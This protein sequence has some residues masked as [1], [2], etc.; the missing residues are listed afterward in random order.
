M[1]SNYKDDT[2]TLVK[3]KFLWYECADYYSF[4]LFSFWGKKELQF[5]D[6][7]KYKEIILSD[8]IKKSFV[9]ISTKALLE[10]EIGIYIPIDQIRFWI[11]R[12]FKEHDSIV[13]NSKINDFI[14]FEFDGWVVKLSNYDCVG[15]KVIF[16]EK[17]LENFNIRVK[18]IV[19]N[20]E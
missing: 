16:L 19:K 14:Y 8:G 6:F 1:Q 7:F 3:G 15:P 11:R 5:S 12:S 18:L 17:T 10:R 2:T 9:N 20:N 13:S 4:S